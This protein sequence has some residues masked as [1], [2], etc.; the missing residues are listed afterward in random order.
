MAGALALFTAGG[1]AAVDP[2]LAA[3]LLSPPQELSIG[4]RA[5]TMPTIAAALSRIDVV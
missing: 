5:S 4:P 1:A 3:V 2:V